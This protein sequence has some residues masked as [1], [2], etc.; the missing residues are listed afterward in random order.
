M[1]DIIHPRSKSQNTGILKSKS[2]WLLKQTDSLVK[3]Y[4]KKFIV[5][6]NKH[7]YIYRNENRDSVKSYINFDQI[8]TTINKDPKN[9]G[10]LIL[11]FKGNIQKFF[12]KGNP[13]EII[14]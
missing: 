10:K 3:V 13:V 6:E 5:L 14:E 4:K 9:E 11:S 8:A 7:L 2:G 1:A 12:F